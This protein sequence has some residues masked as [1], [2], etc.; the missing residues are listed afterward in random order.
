M[1][2]ELSP[3][4]V[5]RGF[6]HEVRQV[7]AAHAG[8]PAR[9]HLQA[10]RC[11]QGFTLGVD[12]EDRQSL[13]EVGQGNDD[14]TVET[15]RAQQRGVEHVGPVRRGDDDD[16]FGGVEAVHLVEH[17]VEGLLAFV[18]SAADARTALAPDGVDLVDEDDGGRLLAGGRE[19]VA[20]AARADAHEHLHEV[21][22]RDREERHAR[23]ARDR[24]R[25][26]GLAGAGR[27]DEQDPLGDQGADLLVAPRRLQELHDLADLLL[28]PEV[29]RHVG[30]GGLR[31]VLVELLGLG[32]AHGH[33][34]VHLSLGLAVRE[35]EETNED[36]DPDEVGQE[37]REEAG[38][39]GERDRHVVGAQHVDVARDRGHRAV[40]GVVRAVGELS[41]DDARGVVDTGGDDLGVTGVLQQGR[42]REGLDGGGR[43]ER[44]DEQYPEHERDDRDRDEATARL[45]RHRLVAARQVLLEAGFFVRSST[46][47][48][49][50]RG[51]QRQAVSGP[52]K[53]LDLLA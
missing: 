26:H 39:V 8:R 16:A 47:A 10:H 18:V 14:L 25:Q 31:T 9:D 3:H 30:E 45:G 51:D 38:G 23:F 24:T 40:H 50:S 2:S 33:H 37:G 12:L 29:A 15:T 42:V 28:D 52:F 41:G 35:D 17:L 22:S 11:V 34:A 43:V 32:P 5:Q 49:Q 27:T 20:H 1:V 21:R 44:L 7:G 6:V 46:H 19:E 48:L 13:V 4:G 53:S 36:E